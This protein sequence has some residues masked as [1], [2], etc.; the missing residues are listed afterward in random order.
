MNRSKTLRGPC[1]HCG[2][3]LEFPVESTGLT[4]DCPLC[5]RP[6]ELLLARPTEEPAIPRKTIIWTFVAVLILAGGLAG[7]IAALS[8][9]KRLADKKKKPAATLNGTATNETRG[10]NPSRQDGFHTSEITLEKVP[11]G[12][13][14]YAIGTLTNASARQRFGVKIELELLDAQGK[15]IGT[16]TDYRGV[17][18]PKAFWQF[19]ALVVDPKATVAARLSQI[20]EDQ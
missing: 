1:S 10:E 16:A 4:I 18:E 6:T 13:L 15:R 20:K 12:S 19:R 5:G 11:G 8:W 14:V 17:L 9:G 2:G 3:L 7:S